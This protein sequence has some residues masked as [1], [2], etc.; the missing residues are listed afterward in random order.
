MFEDTFCPT[1]A[2][3]RP[4][5]WNIPPWLQVTLYVG[6][7]VV[8][9]LFAYGFLSPCP[10]VA[11]S[12]K[13]HLVCDHLPDKIRNFFTFGVATKKVVGENQPAGIMHLNLM[14]GMLILF[15]G[16]VLATID[17]DVTRLFF[18]FRIL[19]G[20]FYFFYKFVL[21]IVGLLAF[22]A[23]CVAIYIRYVKKPRRL[24]GYKDGQLHFDDDL[25]VTG[26][27]TLLV[28]TGFMIESLRISQMH[29]W[30]A[31]YSP[32]GNLAGKHLD[33]FTA[34]HCVASASRLLGLSRR[35]DVIPHRVCAALEMVSYFLQQHEYI[36]QKT[37]AERD[38]ADSQYRGARKFWHCQV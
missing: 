30:W 26:S 13:A 16:T 19:Q 12:A 22:V 7:L 38:C 9:L 2:I 4:T 11:R 25:F 20:S 21:D 6:G 3:C 34:R 37:S 27:F 1:D 31:V 8:A 29:P 35:A 17:W 18:H 10:A 28:F 33:A 23:L 5:F 36:F 32:I 14:W 24:W 15:L